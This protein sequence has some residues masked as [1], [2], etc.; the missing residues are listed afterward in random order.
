M[1]ADAAA[2]GALPAPAEPDSPPAGFVDPTA[3]DPRLREWR[4]CGPPR[5]FSERPRERPPAA[6]RI[7]KP[8]DLSADAV[9]QDEAAGEVHFK[10]N[11]LVIRADQRLLA[12]ELHYRREGEQF[13]ARGNVHYIDNRFEIKA[14]EATLDLA[15]EHGVVES[16]RYYLPDQHAY[17]EAEHAEIEGSKTSHY[18]RATY[19]TCAPEDPFWEVRARSLEL[20][21]EGRQGVARDATLAIRDTPVFYLPY[22]RF[23]IGDERM[24]GFL[25]PH[26]GLS[27]EN[28][29]E[30]DTPWYWNIAPDRDATI[31]PMLFTQRG[32]MMGGEYRYLGEHAQGE[33][34]ATFLP[35]DQESGGNRG[36]VNFQHASR[37]G[38]HWS[39]DVAIRYAGD[40]DYFKDFGGNLAD[41]STR[42]LERHVD[43]R[44]RDRRNTF[45]ARVQSFQTLDED[46]APT[47][48]SYDRLPQFVWLTRMPELPLGLRATMRSEAVAFERGDTV[49][50]QRADLHPRLSWRQEWAAGFVDP[51]FGYR[52]TNY[53]LQDE[54]APTDDTE[55]RSLPVTSVDSG[56]FFDRATHLLGLPV[57]QTLE[58]RAFY[59]YVPERDQ[60][61]I[62][63]FDTREATLSYPALFR[64]NRFS[65]TDRV[66][67]AN[68]L[69]VGVASR[70]IEDASGAE[71]LRLGL[72]VIRY[73]RN[74][75][76]A[77]PGE[78]EIQS[79]TSDIVGELGGRPLRAWRAGAVLQWDPHGEH[80][81]RSG[82]YL[83]YH[84]GSSHVV[85]LAFRRRR[86]EYEELGLAAVWPVAP[87][88]RVVGLW[89]RD[90][91]D[92]LLLQAAGGFEYEGCCHVVRLIAGQHLNRDASVEGEDRT[93][94]SIRL[95][96]ELKGMTSIGDR[97]DRQLGK[98]IL[99][100][101]VEE[102]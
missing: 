30:L 37:H 8:V 36:I 46:L 3:L 89:D 14:P 50:G 70:Y 19:T 28:G 87:Q 25:T 47:Q 38:A 95:Q 53:W 7:D 69:T 62:P 44:Y 94:E 16:P 39:T 49:T 32:L 20:D 71:R 85:N 56:L 1:P 5:E 41:S 40:K 63:V 77:L 93:E 22:W 24:S 68:Q 10:G 97:V 31:T 80:T 26:V 6:V 33:L 11:V 83:R 67:D 2:A 91:G 86:G 72:G 74:L 92:D 75:D 55:Q 90:L 42:H 23:P 13:T 27:S 76:V 78:G 29:F 52:Y 58:P 9:E 101:G 60:D 61:D 17:G 100:Y 65:G 34:E 59:L 21:H 51:A 81:N 66:G 96:V 88:W 45:L 64:E 12:D 18:R 15:T 79:D 99:G 57:T 73:F 54:S 84:P 4:F 82:A 35:D 102:D 48:R 43:L 98:T